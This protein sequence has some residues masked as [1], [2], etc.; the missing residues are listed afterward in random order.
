ME[1]MISHGGTAKKNLNLT[2][3]E[4][5]EADRGK[6]ISCKPKTEKWVYNEGSKILKTLLSQLMPKTSETDGAEGKCCGTSSNVHLV[7]GPCCVWF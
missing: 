2:C 4:V 7:W 6:C 1:M 5:L 3:P